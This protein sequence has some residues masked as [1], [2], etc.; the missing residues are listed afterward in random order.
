MGM[1]NV[2]MYKINTMAGVGD[3]LWAAYNTGMVHVYDTTKNPWIVRKDWR[4]HDN[5]VISLIADPSS[6]YKMDKFQVVSLG[7]D[8]VVRNWDGSLQEDWL[9]MYIFF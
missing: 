5:P 6:S 7:A 2:T 4:A 9:G 1:V 3:Y 8:N